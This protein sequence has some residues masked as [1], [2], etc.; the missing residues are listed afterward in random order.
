MVGTLSEET[1]AAEQSLVAC[2]LLDPSQVE[3]VG[4]IIGPSDFENEGF[5]G[6]FEAVA[7]LRESGV[8]A[9]LH[10]VAARLMAQGTLQMAG[11]AS[12]LSELAE[13][14]FSGSNAVY[15]ARTVLDLS[16]KR[17]V[18]GLCRRGD[19]MSQD[20][21]P[22][23]EVLD[24]LSGEFERL[25]QRLPGA[26]IA[27]WPDPV[28]F[29]S[30]ET[31]AIDPD[32]IPSPLRE[33]CEGV[34][35]SVQV[36]FELPVMGALGAVA[37]AAQGKF[38]VVVRPGYFEPLSIYSVTVLPPGERKSASLD[39]CK[40]PLIQWEQERFEILEPE[41]RRARS[42]LLTRQKAI[43]KARGKAPSD[44]E[45]LR[46]VI[47]AVQAL[48][49]TLPKVPVAPR[50][51][52][53]D[54]TPEAMGA[55]MAEQDERASVIEAEGGLFSI[56]AGMYSSGTPNLN[57]VLKSWSSESSTVD[58]RSRDTIRLRDPALSITLTPQ[59]E[60]LRDIAEMPGFRG[61]G[62]LGRFLYCLP[63]SRLGTR[64]IETLPIPETV[65]VN[66][67][68]MVFRILSKPWAQDDG[69]NRT[70][71]IIRLS[72]PAY[73]QWISFAEAVELEL[74][75]GG[76]FELLRDWAGKLP[77]QAIRL[78]GLFHVARAEDPAGTPVPAD[79]M[80]K[81]LRLA[82]VLADHARAAFAFMG[83]DPAVEC[84]R[85][86]LRWIVQGRV[87]AFTARD[88][89]EKVKGSFPKMEQVSPGLRV[90]EDRYYIRPVQAD[91]RTG[92]GRKPS[93]IFKVNPYSY[94]QYSHNSY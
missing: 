74:R 62:L 82:A 53:D 48:E 91:P 20:G 13:S 50:L 3:A 41:I 75:D 14:A 68:S 81:A 59:N 27:G 52:C 80:D 33:F 61:R 28:P 12:F 89:F 49:E 67:R 31:P 72:E 70:P 23:A 26:Q 25:R 65:R 1:R 45:K 83:S 35:V 10:A 66:Y 85:K 37:T 77:G 32:M 18:R 63:V 17:Q 64:V 79:T 43:D 93:P 51:L 7:D 5:A 46:E 21:K 78:S 29:D 40:K 8:T 88:A 94:S 34:S 36:P 38:K 11:G 57:L 47:R 22:T 60:V 87:E 6:V 44:P 92:P 58:R 2:L 84:G 9:D 73:R 71:Y 16:L 15:H 55:F 86:I 24:T 19:A 54:I 39:A 4:R 42:E 69:G 90:L 30:V 76:Q 56:L